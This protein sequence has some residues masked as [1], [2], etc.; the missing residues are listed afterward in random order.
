M[1]ARVL[2]ART[3]QA[4]GEGVSLCVYVCWC[5]EEGEGEGGRQEGDQEEGE[6]REGIAR[7]DRRGKE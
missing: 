4:E 1:G 6:M 5:H 2:R 7:D 3:V